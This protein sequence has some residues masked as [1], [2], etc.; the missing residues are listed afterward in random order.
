MHV[1]F[2]RLAPGLFLHAGIIT[3]LL[4]LR[5][6]LSNISQNTYC[7]ID[8][9]IICHAVSWKLISMPCSSGT[10]IPETNS[11]PG[12]G[13]CGS[14]TA[15]PPER[16]SIPGIPP[17]A[18]RRGSY[19]AA[20]SGS[21]IPTQATFCPSSQGKQINLG[22][23]L[24]LSIAHFKCALLWYRND[25]STLM[26]QN[27]MCAADLGRSEHWVNEK[28][29]SLTFSLFGNLN[30]ALIYSLEILELNPMQMEW[31]KMLCCL[32]IISKSPRCGNRVM[33]QVLESALWT[34]FN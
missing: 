13:G 30:S 29:F 7:T 11:A 16:S 27:Q 19:S 34:N 32:L 4:S 25:L 21:Q 5:G 26:L 28:S 31:E 23:R 3:A 17:C 6:V 10:W 15:A 14:C 12:C 33:T 9:F 22:L 1:H 2:W 18:P 20:G 8:K 24:Q